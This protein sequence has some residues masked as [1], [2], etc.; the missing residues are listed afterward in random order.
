MD[1]LS[2]IWSFYYQQKILKLNWKKNF[3]L[4]LFSDTIFMFNKYLLKQVEI[5]SLVRL[6]QSWSLEWLICSGRISTSCPMWKKHH[7]ILKKAR[8]KYWK[9]PMF[10]KWYFSSL[11]D[12]TFP[13]ERRIFC[14][15]FRMFK[16]NEP[17]AS[18]VI[19]RM[20]IFFTSESKKL[21]KKKV[22]K[23]VFGLL[24]LQ[25]S[26]DRSYS[27]NPITDNIDKKI[28]LVRSG[29]QDTWI[30]PPRYILVD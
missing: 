1:C 3:Q 17:N 16:L 30:Y 5:Y 29:N 22:P 21:M 14:F 25:T 11:T 26:M 24:S 8:S 9:T 13:L 19:K 4:V 2:C 12:M 18:I 27:S 15:P 10:G 20:N 23:G 6:L 28:K 7:H